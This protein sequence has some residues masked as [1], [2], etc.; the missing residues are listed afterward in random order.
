MGGTT[1]HLVTEQSWAGDPDVREGSDVEATA[2]QKRRYAQARRAVIREL[3][4]AGVMPHEEEL[5]SDWDLT[6]L[7]L[8][9]RLKVSSRWHPDG[10]RQVWW[11]VRRRAERRHWG[12]A[13][14]LNQGAVKGNTS[15]MVVQI[16]MGDFAHLLGQLTRLQRERRRWLDAPPAD[17]GG[18]RSG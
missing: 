15:H 2:T 11:H 14:F 6:N 17:D 7:P 13:V 3:V 5:G 16:E 1:R 18:S 12:A 8:G 4:G 9:G 10:R